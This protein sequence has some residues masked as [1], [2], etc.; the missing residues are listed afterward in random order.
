M[1]LRNVRNISGSNALSLKKHW[2]CLAKQFLIKNAYYV[3]SFKLL[4]SFFVVDT[5]LTT[6][7]LL[8]L[9]CEQYFRDKHKLKEHIRRHTF[10]KIIA[11]PDCGGMFSNRTKLLDHLSR[12]N[13][14]ACTF[15]YSRY[16]AFERRCMDVVTAS[17]SV[18]AISLTFV[19]LRHFRW[20]RGSLR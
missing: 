20:F 15:L 16:M 5:V 6:I 3:D 12:Q 11:C 17:S 8:F 14:E 9:A 1:R 19:S 7:Q 13:P 2:V 18:D 10:E 4:F